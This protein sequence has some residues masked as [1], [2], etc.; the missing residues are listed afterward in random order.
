[1][2]ARL[3]AM[4]QKDHVDPWYT[5][6]VYDGIGETDHSIE[7]LQRAYNERSSSLY[8]MKVALLSERVRSDPRFVA[9]LRRMNF[10]AS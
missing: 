9:L 2:L 7:Y 6:W 4:A 5:S 8:I 3:Q 10:P 1:M